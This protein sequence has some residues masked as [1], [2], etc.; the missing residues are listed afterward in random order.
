MEKHKAIGGMIMSFNDGILFAQ[1]TK[2][3]LTGG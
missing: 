2:I 3:P 1:V